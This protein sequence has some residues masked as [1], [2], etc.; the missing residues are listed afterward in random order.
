MDF[1]VTS[2]WSPPCG[3]GSCP[4]PVSYTHL[5]VYKRQ[6]YFNQAYIKLKKIR[7]LRHI[8]YRA[9][10]QLLN[11]HIRYKIQSTFLQNTIADTDCTANKSIIAATQFNVALKMN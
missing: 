5:D 4:C 3:G 2:S 7:S 1:V 9:L 6:G 10:W 8:D 11:I